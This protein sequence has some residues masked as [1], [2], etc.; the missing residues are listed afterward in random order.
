MSDPTVWGG[1]RIA[2]SPIKSLIRGSTPITS[3]NVNTIAMRFL[4]F[5]LLRGIDGGYLLS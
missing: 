3:F 5:L 2:P 4:F 1:Y